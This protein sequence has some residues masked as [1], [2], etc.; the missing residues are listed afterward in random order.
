MVFLG[1]SSKQKFPNQT[2]MSV[3]EI[4]NVGLADGVDRVSVKRIHY[5]PPTQRSVS[6]ILTSEF[7]K[8]SH[9]SA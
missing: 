3:S 6:Q 8:M 9:Q 2:Q 7:D 5:L 4:L 1:D